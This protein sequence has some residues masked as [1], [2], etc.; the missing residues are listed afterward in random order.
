LYGEV[1]AESDD[2][3]DMRL[4]Y[5]YGMLTY[6]CCTIPPPY[7]SNEITHN[8]LVEAVELSHKLLGAETVVLMTIPF[9]NNV[10][11]VAEMNKVNRIN[12]D[13]RDIAKGWHLRNSTGVKYVLVLEYGTYYN[14]IIWSNA[15]HMGYNVSAPLMMT[16]EMF[17]LEGPT[18]LYDRLQNGKEWKPSIAQVCSVQNWLGTDKAKCNRNYLFIDGMHICPETLATRYGVAVACLL[19]CVYNRKCSDDN[20]R[21]LEENKL[22]ACELE[23]NEQFISVMPVDAALLFS[24]PRDVEAGLSLA[25]FAGSIN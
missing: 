2:V 22:R 19:G 5:T 17:D 14:H 7:P 18:F 4:T 23:C 24:S 6:T 12:D 20:R 10:D 9:T 11:T 13:I 16:K 25:S 21:R 1:D 15:R 3:K 8:R